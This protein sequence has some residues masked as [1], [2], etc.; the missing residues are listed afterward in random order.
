MNRRSFL[1]N[2][3]AGTA[4][5]AVTP[6]AFLASCG[7]IVPPAT[8][9]AVGG[10]EVPAPPFTNEFRTLNVNSASSATITASKNLLTL[11]GITETF[12]FGYNADSIWG[13]T[14]KITKGNTANITLTNNINETT[15]LNFRGLTLDASESDSVETGLENGGSKTYNF[16]VNNRAGL[17]MYQPHYQKSAGYQTHLGLGGFFLVEDSEESSLNLPEGELKSTTIVVSDKRFNDQNQMYYG[18]N[19]GEQMAG[20]FGGTILV[21]GI[22]GPFKNV[23]TRIH[24][25]RIANG[26][27][28]RI[29]NFGLTD[30]ATNADIPFRIIGGDCGLLKTTGGDITTI[31]LAPGERVDTLVDLSA[32]AE[33]TEIMLNSRSFTGGGD[34]QGTLGFDIMKF[35]I[36][37]AE[38]ETYSIP[39]SLSDVTTLTEGDVTGETRNLNISNGNITQDEAEQNT[40]SMHVISGETYDAGTVNYTVTAGTTEKWV[41]NNTDG[42]E[43]RAMHIQG[44]Q[45]QILSREGGRGTTKIWERSWKD[46]VL[47]LPGETVTCIVP[48]TVAPGKYNVVCTNLENSDSGL[49]HTIEVV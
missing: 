11:I 44:V 15:N 28:A 6:A 10:L 35:V 48:F 21:N 12:C 1:R 2:T 33:G 42:K 19:P 17:Y 4:A 3:L 32:M 38:T 34:Y 41:F 36:T 26:S 7:E 30:V 29:F 31:L 22:Q 14:L 39:D 16:T 27:N 24:R 43:P 46:T 25:L 45:F 13:P 20:F 5:V 40:A 49:M 18:P 8:V 37:L 23:S 9:F 47:M